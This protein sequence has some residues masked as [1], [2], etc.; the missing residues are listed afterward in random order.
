M[1]KNDLR[2][3]Y[4]PMYPSPTRY[5]SSWLYLWER[6]LRELCHVCPVI[7]SMYR[8]A[9]DTTIN[10]IEDVCRAEWEGKQLRNISLKFA[11]G[12]VSDGDVFLFTEGH[13]L[14]PLSVAKLAAVSG[15][16]ICLAVLLH[17]GLWDPHDYLHGLDGKTRGWMS[18]IERAI[19]E[20]VD[21]VLLATKFHKRLIEEA[22]DIRGDEKLVVTGYP[23]DLTR[24]DPFRVPWSDRAPV[25][26]FPHRLTD[27]KG[28]D[29]LDA[30]RAML[31]KSIK[32]VRT[33]D[34][35]KEEDA[36]MQTYHAALASSRCVLSCAKQETWGIAQLEGWYLGAHPI[37]PRRLSYAELYPQENQYD[38][39][40]EAR[41]L[42]L[43]LVDS[44]KAATYQ[45]S[46][47]TNPASVFPK[48]IE[49]I[50]EARCRIS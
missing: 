46:R 25:V 28:V 34:L 38:T 42:V 2:I 30:I 31:P 5:A 49:A 3:H 43:R 33:N 14:L 48:I 37:V 26:C 21:V 39:V 29:D 40:E 12:Q 13:S 19:L 11:D 41:D 8:P 20:A 18:K 10:P 7:P 17:A 44:K 45:P 36:T 50:E 35:M 23:L 6:N 16:K 1:F 4:V 47:A 15:K 27:S 32:I 22:F 9:S 24:L